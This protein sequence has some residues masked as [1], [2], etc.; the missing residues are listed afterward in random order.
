MISMPRRRWTTIGAEGWAS[1]AE[2]FCLL[3]VVTTTLGCSRGTKAAPGELVLLLST[4][5][6]VPESFDTILLTIDGGTPHAYTVP[7][8]PTSPN[9]GA[10]DSL[11]KDCK[12]GDSPSTRLEFPT[13][14]ALV[15][16]RDEAAPV[17]LTLTACKAGHKIFS[18]QFSP[19][20][21]AAGGLE[22]LRA[23]IRWLCTDWN[24]RCYG[25]KVSGSSQTDCHHES[26]SLLAN[27][28][29]CQSKSLCDEASKD[30]FVPLAYD[31]DEVADYDPKTGRCFDPR[32][33]F[34]M[35]AQ[36]P[37]AEQLWL[38]VPAGWESPNGSGSCVVTL[39][40][41]L[42]SDSQ[43]NLALVL[44][45]GD[46]GFCDKFRCLVPLDALEPAGWQ[47]AS[48]GLGAGTMRLPDAVCNMLD[49]GQVSYLVKSE[50]CQRKGRQM[51]ICDHRTSSSVANW[52]SKSN[53]STLPKPTTYL[54]LDAA[55][56]G[57]DFAADP[58]YESSNV[59]LKGQAGVFS[60]GKFAKKLSSPA[61][62]KDKTLSF[63]LSLTELTGD[64]VKSSDEFVT[65][66]LS[67]ISS[68]CTTGMRLELRT[69]N[70]RSS[71]V[72]AVGIPNPLEPTPN[73]CAIN[74][75]FAPLTAKNYAGGFFTPWQRGD[76]YHVAVSL[77]P[78]L[79]PEVFV[80]GTKSSVGL[81]SGDNCQLQDSTVEPSDGS[82]L[83]LGSP[84]PSGALRA[85]DVLIDEVKFFGDK[86]SVSQ[87]EQLLLES[88]TAPGASGLLW[89]AWST[90]G[91]LALDTSCP[92]GSTASMDTTAQPPE[93]NI[94]D[95]GASSSG[96]YALLNQP[97]DLTE[98]PTTTTNAAQTPSIADFD[99][100]LLVATLPAGEPFQF[101]LVAEHGKRQCTWQLFGN[102]D[103]NTPSKKSSDT[104]VID[105]RRPSWCID[106]DCS[107]D[108]N[109]VER[110]SL[111]SDWK[112]AWGNI[113]YT[114]R[115]L[116]F[117]R[118][119]NRSA[120]TLA[121]YGGLTGLGGWCWKP[122]AY[123][124]VWESKPI[125]VS[126]SK[127]VSV[128]APD[129]HS[130]P[131]RATTDGQDPELAADLPPSP[132]HPASLDLRRCAAIELCLGVGPSNPGSK[133]PMFVLQ[134]EIGQTIAWSISNPDGCP[135]VN[136]L[137]NPGWPDTGPFSKFGL[138]DVR[139]SVTRLS[140]RYSGSIAVSSIRCCTTAGDASSCA[141]IE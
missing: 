5:M 118:R 96:S 135:I 11:D 25:C 38:Q 112:V 49:S 109:N 113:D 45:P 16:Q 59:A 34:N 95:C 15:S 131:P 43:I 12:A 53:T 87:I 132:D 2:F 36:S 20:L 33:C 77:D 32:A 54:S 76:F 79:G 90:R 30:F 122:V 85:H 137:E 8:L 120:L 7:N 83:Y 29:P 65:P 130:S 72:L 110:A 133:P 103:A 81:V 47:W 126:D 93:F 106:P 92:Q 56:L 60:N 17:D 22:M 84:N 127:A 97:Q 111:G 75:E 48:S 40:P 9:A 107:F 18:K 140:V 37:L 52:A 138:D 66:I 57:K 58:T 3:L 41:G 115:S 91:T 100:A 121:G 98:I 116:T 55:A 6:E 23:P 94:Y 68:S 27:P 61:E 104:Y 19:T 82:A 4:D 102:Y 136:L 73:G 129:S 74:Y 78:N 10:T 124:P 119:P 63:W 114:V 101:A 128:D 67:N 50:S 1:L 44:P 125:A 99:E 14:I 69:C 42:S 89:G 24:D 139:K 117:R 134:N 35:G 70:N 21:P 86:L 141:G 88:S 105:L 39:G 123:D 71:V 26:I 64:D 108:I 28:S 51:P 80:D 46:K 13:T 62:F 31:A